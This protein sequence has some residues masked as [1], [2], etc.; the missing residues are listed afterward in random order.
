MRSLFRFS[1]LVG[2][3]GLVGLAR[4]SGLAG[5]VGVGLMTAGCGDGGSGPEASAEAEVQ[6]GA[7]RYTV[8][9]PE[10]LGVYRSGPGEHCPGGL[11]ECEHVELRKVDGKLKVSFG[12]DAF[13]E[14]YEGVT[15]VWATDSGVLVFSI[16]DGPWSRECDDPGCGDLVKI[17][18]VIYPVRDGDRWV[19]QVKATYDAVFHFPDDER[20]PEG[21]VRTVM[22]LRQR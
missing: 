11:T 18:G 19:P 22:R 21:D 7:P 16:D 15:D 17:S 5:L 2:L 10:V 12:W 1:S 3:F 20:A 14:G 8:D 4:L 6:S 9:S 13:E